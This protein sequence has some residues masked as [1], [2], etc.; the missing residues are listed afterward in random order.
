[1]R[2]RNCRKT[3]EE[4]RQHETAVKIRKMTDK[5]ICSFL[6]ELQHSGT[7]SEENRQMVINNF[8]SSIEPGN[9]IGQATIAKLRSYARSN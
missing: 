4:I 9:G 7:I 1:M 5:Q 6:F 8:I 3:E 2:K